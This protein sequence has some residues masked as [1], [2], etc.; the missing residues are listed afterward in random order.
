MNIR[1]KDMVSSLEYN[2]LAKLKHDLEKGGFHLYKLV[3]DV[4]KEKE[5]EH[6]KRCAVCNSPLN[7]DSVNNITLIFGPSDFR[8]KASFCG[9]DCLEY[10]LTQLRKIKVEAYRETGKTQSHSSYGG[11]S[12]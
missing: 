12:D 5:M 1:V 11:V 7:P 6:N 2:E 4:F 3:N 9:I 10:F 8:K